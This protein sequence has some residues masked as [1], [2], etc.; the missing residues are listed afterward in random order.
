MKLLKSAK[1]MR[2]LT[3]AA[4]A[5]EAMSKWDELT[6]R[7]VGAA[8]RGQ[9]GLIFEEEDAEVRAELGELLVGLGYSVGRNST[10]DE[11]MYIRW[12]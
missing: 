11:L 2:E 6:E 1:E 7:I 12:N 9:Y 4:I 8:S 3:Q 5:Q 10:F